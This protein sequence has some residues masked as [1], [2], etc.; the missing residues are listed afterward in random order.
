M[1]PSDGSYF[2]IYL[3]LVIFETLPGVGR[4]CLYIIILICWNN[5]E[6][7]Y[8][9]VLSIRADTVLITIVNYTIPFNPTPVQILFLQSQEQVRHQ[10]FVYR[11][12]LILDL[13][14][15]SQPVQKAR[16]LHLPYVVTL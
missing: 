9:T 16:A 11:E 13:F 8:E 5:D 7:S 15:S 4:I 3:N 1:S 12:L 2:Q 10:W 14:V 6:Y